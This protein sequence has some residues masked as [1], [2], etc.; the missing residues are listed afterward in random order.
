M[1]DTL[2]NTVSVFATK[3]HLRFIMARMAIIR[4]EDEL[5]A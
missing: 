5:R 4:L 2:K 1:I 3:E